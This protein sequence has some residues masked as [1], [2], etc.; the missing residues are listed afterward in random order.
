MN[1]KQK[2]NNKQE[3]CPLCENSEKTI[4]MLNKT[5]N[6]KAIKDKSSRKI[7]A[8]FLSLV[9]IILV[10]VG[11]KLL[12][13]SSTNPS[14]N[15][16]NQ[17]QLGSDTKNSSLQTNTQAPDFTAEDVY[18]N[19]VSLSDY[20]NKKPVLLAFWAT[21]CGY[22]DKELPDLKNF[23]QKNQDQIQILIVDSGESKETIKD[24]VQEKEID[25][26]T[27]IDEQRKIWNQYLVRGTPSHFLIDKDG[28]IVT[29]RPGLATLKNLETMLS[30]IKDK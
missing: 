5:K 26:L 15:N 22:C 29:M 1:K 20:H 2:N 14:Q 17:E 23:H 27:L 9:I 4:N 11:Y 30:M 21:W 6:S 8:I 28:K 19:K 18:G 16:K 25:F 7:K 3:N 12:S 10:I 13:N 24:Y